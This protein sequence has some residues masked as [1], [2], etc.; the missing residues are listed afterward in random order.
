MAAGEFHFMLGKC[1]MGTRNIIGR[2][3]MHVGS[4][5]HVSRGVVDS[6]GLGLRP[7]ST[8][9]RSALYEMHAPISL[10]I[11]IT[12]E[13][14]NHEFDAPTVLI[15]ARFIPGPEFLDGSCPTTTS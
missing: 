8:F 5:G 12:N 6:L 4:C 7:N 15:P 11:P 9:V 3:I 10:P 1:L 13:R 2:R 14:Y